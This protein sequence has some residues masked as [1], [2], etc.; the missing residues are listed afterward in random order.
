[1]LIAEVVDGSIPQGE[2]WHQMLLQQM[3]LEIPGIRPAVISKKAYSRLNEY[4]GFR[5][6]VRNVY[7]YRFDPAKIEKLV[8]GAPGLFS[9]ARAELLAFADFIDQN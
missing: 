3:T 7:T 9:Q 8:E 6:V 2:N 4:L 1:M 5:H